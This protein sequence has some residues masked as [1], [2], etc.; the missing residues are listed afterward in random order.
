MTV[1]N[2]IDPITVEVIRS[3]FQ[4]TANQMSATLV[5]AAFSPIIYEVRDFS[6]GVYNSN[7]E[8][9][10]EGPGLP[11]FMGTLAF[12]I[13]TVID[14]VGADT[15]CDGDVLL[16]NY[17]YWTGAHSQDAVLIR[18]VF[19][20]GEIFGYIAVKAHW[21]DNGAKDI[22]CTD[23]IDVFQE[24]LQ[25]KVAKLVRAG[26]VN[27]ELVE[28][29][30]TNSRLPEALSGDLSAQ[31]A[32]CDFGE[33]RFSDLIARYGAAMVSAAITSIL[34]HGERLAR[35][36]IAEIPDGEWIAESALDNDGIGT[37]PI[38]IRLRLIIAG[39]TITVDLDGSAPQTRGPMNCPIAS[40]ISVL[41]LAMKMIVAPH[42]DANE[43]F[44]R[45]LEVRA[46]ERSVVNPSYPAP[47]MLYG[48]TTMAVGEAVFDAFSQASPERSVA[49]SGGDIG[50]LLFSGIDSA[51]EY[52]AG[53]GDEGCGAGA[54]DDD[55]GESAII[56]FSL[57]GA[58]NIPVE[59]LE[60]RFPIV[61][62]FYRLRRDSGGAGRN[63]GG[64]G[65]DRQWL[66]LADTNLISTIEQTRNA[67]KGVAGGQASDRNALVL[68]P[69]TSDEQVVGKLSGHLV[70]SGERFCVQTRGGAGWGAPFD[71][72]AERV[73]A[74]V[75]SGYVSIAAAERDYGV[76]CIANGAN[77]Q[78]DI[79]ATTAR[80]AARGG[81]RIGIVDR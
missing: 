18:P 80:R 79:T 76:V 16:C 7:A 56:H 64:L 10:A 11:V 33:R 35:Q 43:G 17:P 26:A 27:Q 55:D 69:A 49:R 41:R 66:V 15:V 67:P 68:R 44:F 48:W 77:I 21:M 30:Q 65:L 59:I 32:A 50:A 40:T 73:I 19:V 3:Y 9:I 72:D 4:S 58:R 20:A 38:G 61:T 63:R 13:R 81:A 23:T 25:I 60:E 37:D 12:T 34:D 46:P 54:S 71:R 47:V 22:Y 70:R 8:L 57:G 75:R 39:N 45:A 52:F 31:L 29:L 2:E 51:G 28:I 42:F 6:V 14:H 53:G 62:E 78:V 1:S 24:G 36:A 5:R 74:D